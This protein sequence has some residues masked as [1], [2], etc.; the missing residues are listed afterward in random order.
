MFR[1]FSDLLTIMGMSD[2]GVFE[3]KSTSG[4][5]QLGGRDMD[6]AIIDFLVE[7]FK[8]QSG[9]DITKDPVALQRLTEAAEKAK[10]ELSTTPETDIN[11]PY[12]TADQTG[13]KH[14]QFKLTRSK[15]EQLV[16][17]II[18][19]CKSPVE[20]AISEAKLSTTDIN[21]IILVGGPTRMPAVKKFVEKVV[22]QKIERG[23]DPME[24]VAVGAAIQAGIL[25]GDVKD[26]LLLDVTPLSLGIETL[27][28]VFTQLIEK[29]T[30][31][32]TKKTQVF[33]TAADNQPAVTI[34]V[35]QGERAMANDNKHL[36]QFD[37]VGIPPAARGV[38]QIEVTFD[39]DA[40]GIVHV[41]AKDLGT[42]KEQSI[43]ITASQKLSEEE[44]E[45]MRKQADEH[46]EEDKKRREEIE[47]IN[48]ADSLVYSSEKLFGELK[49][50]V[51]QA[52]IDDVK[53]SV[54][55][56]KELLKPEQKD[57]AKV[58]DMV[59][60]ITNKTQELSTEL[61]QK[62]AAAQQEAQASAD[63]KE[64]K[65]DEKIVDAEVKKEDE[66]NK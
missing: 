39:I 4:D 3:V 22:G 19:R 58:K 18:Q 50:K 52:K 11:L 46:A 42:G 66:K 6:K 29:N 54:D 43:N 31:I 60:A 25:A 64:N 48:S 59:E 9:V 34:K 41:S 56:L 17:D 10:I 35:H 63:K 5:T 14:F 62:A 51:D 8:I 38:P 30:T 23:V 47:T 36:G 27:G 20:Q 37:L 1:K 13:P 12:L 33:S 49:D 65:K 7:E 61:Y 15:L 28:G 21:K 55:R 40:N 2:D 45:K 53:K 24:C 16:D 32:P 57:I 44:I 26:V